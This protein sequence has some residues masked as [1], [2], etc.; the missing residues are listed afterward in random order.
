MSLDDSAIISSYM[1]INIA[2][3][4]N[5]TRSSSMIDI[6]VLSSDIEELVMETE[7]S[8]YENEVIGCD[9]IDAL[10]SEI[11]YLTGNKLQTSP[12]NVS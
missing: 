12:T 2:V 5:L 10:S 7:D 11:A 8:V 9:R 1:I 6:S 4:R 3:R